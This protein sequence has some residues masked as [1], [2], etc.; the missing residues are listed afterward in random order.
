MNKHTQ[1]CTLESLNTDVLIAILSA[2]NFFSDL[3][4]IIRASPILLHAFRSAKPAVLL[5]VVSNILG[6]ATRDAA[7]L[8]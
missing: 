5:H 6:P 3:A 8:A 2:C 4:S 1:L 7:L